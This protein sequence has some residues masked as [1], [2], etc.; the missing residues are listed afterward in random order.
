MMKVNDFINMLIKAEKSNTVYCTGMFGQP[1]TENSIASKTKQYPDKYDAAKV[2]QLRKL[3]GKNYYGFDCVNLI[4]GILWGWNGDNTKENGG[5][6]YNTKVVHDVD[7]EGLYTEC[8]RSTDFRKIIP[9]ALVWTKGHVG[10]Y[11]GDGNVIECTAKWTNNVL[12]SRLGN[13]GYS[14]K[15]VRKWNGWGK[16]PYID[17][18]SAIG[19][20]TFTTT[21]S[22]TTTAT[23]LVGEGYWQIAK[24]LGIVN[25]YAEI[26]KLNNN[27]ALKPGD[28]IIVPIEDKKPNTGTTESKNDT[29]YDSYVKFVSELRMAL[30]LSSGASVKSV[31]EKTPTLKNDNK[32]NKVTAIVQK[33]LIA[34][35]ISCGSMGANGYFGNDTEKAVKEYQ[36]RYKT[37]VVDGVMSAKGYMWKS[38]LM[39]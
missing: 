11:I 33:Y 36:A 14:G 23:V 19:N 26:A 2:A 17:Y 35:G 9:G 32:Y 16:L 30:G 12:T 39:L 27:K 15:Y 8:E 18:G 5:A 25:K 3:I 6:T 7:T 10:I 22:N 13:L 31:F 29:L 28:T 21:S 24:R 34:L 37:G 1:V 38:L 20:V 4:K